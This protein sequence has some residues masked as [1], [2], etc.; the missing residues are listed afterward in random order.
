MTIKKEEESLLNLFFLHIGG[1]CVCVC[2]GKSFSNRCVSSFFVCCC[3]QESAGDNQGRSTTGRSVPPNWAHGHNHVILCFRLYYNGDKLDPDFPKP[4]LPRPLKVPL[5]RPRGDDE[6]KAALLKGG[7]VVPSLGSP[8]IPGGYGQYH[9]QQH[10]PGMM[11]S[12]PLALTDPLEHRRKILSEVREH[13]DLLKEFEGIISDDDLAQRK[14]ELFRAL[15]PAPPPA[16]DKPSNNN[17]STTDTS[18]AL[19][20]PSKRARTTATIDDEAASS[21]PQL[22]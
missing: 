17:N 7:H 9:H 14:K 15:P 12:P 11:Q 5:E 20:P 22:V 19:V 8:T 21:E 16:K 13:L 10:H 18:S 1:V 2:Q 4:I 3:T 6:S